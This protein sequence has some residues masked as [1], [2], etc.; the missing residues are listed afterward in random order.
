MEGY[1]VRNMLLCMTM[2]C[3][4]AL[5]P[6]A[7]QFVN[8][9]KTQLAINIGKTKFIVDNRL[10][11]AEG[12]WSCANK[13]R[14]VSLIS[15]TV[16]ECERNNI[17][18]IVTSGNVFDNV[19]WRREI[20]IAN[21]QNTLEINYA[22]NIPPKDYGEKSQF[23][24]LKF[25]IPV[26]TLK[27]CQFEYRYGMHRS[28]RP[29]KRGRLTGN[30]PEGKLIASHIRH[31]QFRGKVNVYIDFCPVGVWGLYNND[32]S[33]AYKA[34][35][36]RK[37]NNYVFILP[38]HRTRFGAKCLNKIIVKEGVY[39]MDKIHLIKRLH[40]S[41]PMPALARIQFTKNEP[42][43]GFAVH[44]KYIGWNINFSKFGAQQFSKKIKQGWLNKPAGQVVHIKQN[45]SHG[46]LLSNGFLGQGKATFRIVHSNALVLVNVIFA[47][48]PKISSYNVFASANNSKL[49]KQTVRSFRRETVVIPTRVKNNYIDITINGRNW[50]LCGIIVQYL[51]GAQ[52]DYQ[53]ARSWWIFPEIENIN[54]SINLEKFNNL[55]GGYSCECQKSFVH[56]D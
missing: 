31:I 22:I 23:A 10:D 32:P 20:G 12:E 56:V 46:K 14:N 55:S 6:V 25:Y 8:V 36:L 30:E 43:K 7:G 1:V 52:E 39:D 53:F 21:N 34:H 17:K 54:K 51:L 11:M 38:N 44:P 16:Y 47:G 3:F 29:K 27:G 15:E 2:L 4:P 33:S 48:L 19:F 37:N 41:D 24:R 5:K 49:Y 28:G 40:Y 50:F 18:G 45:E 35:L 42:M 9:D 26:E 13:N